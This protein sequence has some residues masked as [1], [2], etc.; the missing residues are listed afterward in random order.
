MKFD[1]LRK[2]PLLH[3]LSD[4]ELK[5]LVDMGTPVSLRAGELL[6]HQGDIGDSAYII[7]EGKFEVQKLS[8]QSLISIDLRNAG[9]VVGEMALIAQS[10]RTA[11]IVAKTDGKALQI[12]KLAFERLVASSS[13]AA[14]T[15][16]RSVMARLAQ[17]E[18]LLHQQEK[19][20]ALG[21]MSAGLAHELNNPAVAAQRSAAQMQAAQ[22]NYFRLTHEIETRAAQ[23]GQ[24][25]WLGEFMQEAMRRFESP[26]KLAALERI[27]LT[28]QLQTWLEANG[29]E[30]AW[31]LAPAMVA[32]G[33][34]PQSLVPLKTAPL[35]EL[36]IRWLG[37]GCLTMSL[38]AD[39]LEAT[40]R[41]AQIVQAMK[42]YTY[43]DQAPLLEVDIHEGLENTL[44]IMQH[45][46][47]KGITIRREYAPNLPRIEAYASELNQVWTN[48]ID[49]AVDAMSGSGELSLRTYAKNNRVFVEISDNGPGISQEICARI[50]EPFFT[51]KPPGSG[52]GLGLYI[53]HQIIANRHQ[54]Q[55]LVESQTGRT[56]FTVILPFQPKGEI[57]MTDEKTI[58]DILLSTKTIAV[59]G[60]SSNPD[61]PSYSI[62]EYLKKQGYR[63][64][65]VNPTASDILGES[66]YPD[67]TSIPEAVDVVQ[68][69]RKPEDVPPIAEE[70]VKIGA[71]VIWMQEGIVNEEA[72]KTARDAGMQVIMDACMRVM[73]RELIGEK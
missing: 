59:V 14:M 16:L 50:F 15:I 6:I 45:K 23:E 42:S 53:S 28:D 58:K 51:T 55:L 68:V 69:F 12:S 1:L 5:Q 64:I 22:A 29:V 60:L 34:N 27:D 62:A 7:L 71:K 9:D 44:I 3:D 18:S 21:T 56:T 47:K 4:E 38:L 17:N 8:G 66:V 13:G 41:I 26:V 70:A 20:A 67:L 2:S 57:H 33:W 73:H 35:F 52:T 54:G 10:T 31:E 19:M 48:I 65:P 11:S 40:G 49:N 25:E 37:A 32:F 36:S 43:L 46:L 39:V 30:S 61:K 63:I 24:A 72:A